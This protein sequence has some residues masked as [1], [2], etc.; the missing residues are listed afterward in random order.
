MRTSIALLLL[1][2][3]AACASA[4]QRNP[5]A[6]WVPSPNFEARRPVVIVIHATEQ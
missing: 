3:L 4:P 2:L 1:V 6:E 5:L